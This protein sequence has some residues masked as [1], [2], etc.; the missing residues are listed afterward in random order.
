MTT[1]SHSIRTRIARETSFAR[2][3]V[4]AQLLARAAIVAA[5]PLLLIALIDLATPLRE[6][7]AFYGAVVAVFAALAVMFRSFVRNRGS[8]PTNGRIATLLEDEYPEFMDSLHCAL[9]LTATPTK[10]QGLFEA[11]LLQRVDNALA[12]RDIHDVVRRRTVNIPKLVCLAVVAAGLFAALVPLPLPGKALAHARTLVSGS[13]PGLIVTPGN[14]EIGLGDDL[15]IAV[16]IMRGEENAQVTIS[17]A[18]GSNTYAMYSRGGDASAFEIYSV[19]KPFSYVVTTPTLRS[20][21]Y[22]VTT[23]LKPAIETVAITVTPPSYTQLP[24]VTISELKH[25][26]VPRGSRV[27]FAL[28]TNMPCT[29]TLEIEEAPPATFAP[30]ASTALQCSLQVD[31][32]IAFV[33]VL[34]DKHGHIVR[35]E[36]ACNIECVND[37]PPLIQPIT[38]EADAVRKPDDEVTF[39]FKVTDDYGVRGVRLVYAITGGEWRHH[40]LYDDAGAAPPR[41]KTVAQRLPLDG[42]VKSGDVVSYYF[43]ATDN[44]IPLANTSATDVRFIEIRPDKDEGGDKDKQPGGSERKTLKVSDLIVEQKHLIRST[45]NAHRIDDGAEQRDILAELAISAQDLLTATRSRFDEVRGVQPP[46]PIETAIAPPADSVMGSLLESAVAAANNDPQGPAS[47]GVIGELFDQTLNNMEHATRYLTQELINESLTS[48]NKALSNLISIEIEL[49]KNTPPPSEGEEGEQGETSEVNEENKSKK[50]NEKKAV[51]KQVAAALEKLIR[52]Q[53]SVNDQLSQNM[54]EMSE[55]TRQFI[56]RKQENILRESNE[57]RDML[58]PIPEASPADREF[59]EAIRQMRHTLDVLGKNQ[60]VNAGK[61]AQ[62]AH[63]FLR[64]SFEL[65]DDLQN[66]ISGDNLQQ[67]NDMLE[68]IKESQAQ[69]GERTAA[70]GDKDPGSEESNELA[71]EQKQIR[72]SF[73]NLLKNLE[74]LAAGMKNQNKNAARHIKEAVRSSQDENVTG[75]M[76]RSENACR[77]GRMAKASDYQKEAQAALAQLSQSLEN[78]AKQ[79]PTLSQSQLSSM[80]QKTMKNTMKVR[81][82]Q[83]AGDAEKQAMHEAVLEDMQDMTRQLN[84]ELMDQLTDSMSEIVLGQTTASASADGAMLDL[85][86][87]TARLLEAKLMQQNIEQKVKLTRISGRQPPDA[88]RKLVK[89]YFKNLSTMN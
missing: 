22:R 68:K 17:D 45:W 27:T 75:K 35:S 42:L 3:H 29:A 41:E 88:Y 60:D 73:E 11:A 44:A 56:A 84:D 81:G 16:E 36:R 8:L 33:V 78:A 72:E 71:S 74:D 55:G 31:D 5:A 65:I 39:S 52:K 1:E 64:R 9:E 26:A 85:L 54:D 14:T 61:H 34:E 6:D 70:H 38:P 69:L 89:E 2:R 77:Y 83:A 66:T 18:N 57:I 28:E 47:L 87:R 37:F 62:L 40:A 82:R 13:D 76:K 67:A 32:N 51:L 86:H 30:A 4:R 19:D 7:T 25:F 46:E 21:T 12:S 20:P 43:A 59:G 58:R 24:D 15:L 10:Q 80:L 49:Q 50:K 23:F 48:Q 79:S 53:Q 63:Q